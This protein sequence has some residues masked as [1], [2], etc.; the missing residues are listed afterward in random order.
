MNGSHGNKLKIIFNPLCGT[1]ENGT[2]TRSQVIG[3]Y[4]CA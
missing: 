4:V 1:R 2:E 3:C